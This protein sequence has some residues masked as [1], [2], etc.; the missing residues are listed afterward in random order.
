MV[1]DSDM[2]APL[3]KPANVEC[4][5]E[6]GFKNCSLVP[7]LSPAES[8]FVGL[9][10]P[11]PKS[12]VDALLV[13][14]QPDAEAE[15]SS[16]CERGVFDNPM[17][18]AALVE[19]VH[20]HQSSSVALSVHGAG[21]CDLSPDS[22]TKLLIKYPRDASWALATVQSCMNDEL[23]A[24]VDRGCADA[25]P[26][27]VPWKMH[28]QYASDALMVLETN[29]TQQ[30]GLEKEGLAVEHLNPCQPSPELVVDAPLH[31][32]A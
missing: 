11:N 12:V 21:F 22:I 23:L 27:D 15:K 2:R 17:H 14:L 19:A 16:V 1:S 9:L 32:S 5:I 26:F 31:D 4:K 18:G 10:E 7:V 13:V 8:P 3:P 20:E 30:S 6:L 24:V 25:G 28:I 29:A